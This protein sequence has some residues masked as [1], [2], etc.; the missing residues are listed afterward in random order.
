MYGLFHQMKIQFMFIFPRPPKAGPFRAG[1]QR[2]PREFQI[3][4]KGVN[5]LI[6][7]PSLCLPICPCK[8]YLKSFL[9]LQPP[10]NA[11][12]R[13]PEVR[14]KHQAAGGFKKQSQMPSE[15]S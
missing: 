13:K 14:D 9:G 1:K 15:P 2:H 4:C 3:R 12:P 7:L 8:L 11:R 5:G 10:S 6:I